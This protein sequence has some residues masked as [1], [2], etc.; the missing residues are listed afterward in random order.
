MA[1]EPNTMKR[2]MTLL[3][4]ILIGSFHAAYGQSNAAREARL[5]ATY[6]GRIII[7]HEKGLLRATDWSSDEVF[8]DYLDSL[9]YA[10]E[11]LLSTLT[12]DGET[13]MDSILQVGAYAPVLYSDWSCSDLYDL[14]QNLLTQ[15]VE[16][17]TYSSRMN[18]LR[19][20][21]AFFARCE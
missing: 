14:E 6:V 8:V 20:R 4:L 3:M 16:E 9:A 1:E 13:K 12:V 11:Y 18:W 15:H 19:A 2:L 5:E 7:E 21:G 10:R 17:N